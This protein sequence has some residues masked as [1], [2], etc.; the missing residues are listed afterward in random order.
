MGYRV[1]GEPCRGSFRASLEAHARIRLCKDTCIPLDGS[2][3]GSNTAELLV[4][5]GEQEIRKKE[6][7]GVRQ[8]PTYSL[9]LA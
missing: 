1:F 2:T 4:L 8:T 7:Q 6:F 5:Y 3:D 9:P